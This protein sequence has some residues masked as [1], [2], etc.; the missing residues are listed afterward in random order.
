MT[1]LTAAQEPCGCG[2]ECCGEATKSRD[3]EIAELNTLRQS[4]EKRLAEL[5]GAAS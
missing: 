5:E 3:E 4:I 2:C 1:T